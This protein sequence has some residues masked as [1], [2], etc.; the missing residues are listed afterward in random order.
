MSNY[1]LQ[2]KENKQKLF[3][4][5]F[6][7]VILFVGIFVLTDILFPNI[8][9]GSA[10][11]VSAPFW[12]AKNKIISNIIDTTQLIKSKKILV[13]ENKKLKSQTEE[14]N[15]KLSALNLLKRENSF[16]KEM[17]NYSGFNAENTILAETLTIPPAS[18]YDTFIIDAGKDNGI[19]EGYKVLAPSDIFIGAVSEVYKKTSLVK[20]FSSHG[21]ITAVFIGDNN[22]SVNVEGAGG[23]NFTA[24]LP[25]DIGIKKGDIVTIPGMSAN[26][27]AIIEEIETNPTNP[28]VKVFFKNPINMNEIKWVR[29]VKTQ[30]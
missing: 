10:H 4:K 26:V 17:L 14:M 11:F 2:Y 30:N 24:N 15:L 27:F 22:I 1:P 23:G 28:F 6:I 8:F 16:L 3:A 25:R 12:K 13:N 20:L 19:K 18:L 5:T 9:S 29:I 7:I 21:E